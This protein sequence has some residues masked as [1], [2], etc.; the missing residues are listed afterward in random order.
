[1]KYLTLLFLMLPVTLLAQDSEWPSLDTVKYV[2][3]RIAKE[4]DIASKTAIFV[5]KDKEGNYL[6]KP[7]NIK[8]P[9]YAIYTDGETKEKFKVIVVQAESSLEM[10]IYGAI[11]INNGSGVASIDTDFKLLGKVIEK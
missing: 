5:L 8:L 7:I 9:Q 3:G 2:S 1:M 4:A 6:G 10:N 11:N